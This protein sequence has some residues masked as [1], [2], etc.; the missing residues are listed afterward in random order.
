MLKESRAVKLFHTR[1]HGLIIDPSTPEYTGVY[2]STLAWAEIKLSSAWIPKQ[3]ST[4][5]AGSSTHKQTI[6][7][8]IPTLAPLGLRYWLRFAKRKHCPITKPH[9]KLQTV[10]KPSCCRGQAGLCIKGFYPEESHRIYVM[11]ISLYAKKRTQEKDTSL[12]V[13]LKMIRPDPEQW[14]QQA[15]S[16]GPG[17]PTGRWRS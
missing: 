14:G 11:D 13:Q 10:W 4:T 15:W 7:R 17:N 5:W 2:T 12:E 1:R 9:R 16:K 8:E 3:P 6:A